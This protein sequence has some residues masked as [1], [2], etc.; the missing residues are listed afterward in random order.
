MTTSV[1][2]T[3]L[4]GVVAMQSVWNVYHFLP[5]YMVQDPGGYFTEI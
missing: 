1:K 3:V 5:D 2:A 4:W